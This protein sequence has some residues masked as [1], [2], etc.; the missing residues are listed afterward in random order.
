M[1]STDS[2]TRGDVAAAD[3][4]MGSSDVDSSDT[5]ASSWSWRTPSSTEEELCSSTCLDSSLIFGSG[6]LRVSTTMATFLILSVSTLS[7]ALIVRGFIVG[8][9]VLITPPLLLAAGLPLCVFV[10][11]ALHFCTPTTCLSTYHTS[12]NVKS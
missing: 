1:S 9:G 3:D 8:V 10:E 11:I 5:A 4:N 12:P 7:W 2:S 6:H